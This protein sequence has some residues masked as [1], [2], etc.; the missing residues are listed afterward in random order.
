MRVL[1]VLQYPGYLRYFDSV[2]EALSQRGHQV[3]VAFDQPH[4]QREG[5]AALESIDG[6]VE[7]QQPAP[8]RPDIWH[9]V[10]RGGARLTTHDICTPASRS[11]GICATGCAPSCRR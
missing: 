2:L 11:L 4:K 5:L 3:S 8:R 1:F 10:A 6:A 7:V 9:A